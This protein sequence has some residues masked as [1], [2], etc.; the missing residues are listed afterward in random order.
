MYLIFI[1]FSINLLLLTSYVTSLIVYLVQTWSNFEQDVID[2]ATDQS[3]NRLRLCV[4]AGGRHFK[5]ML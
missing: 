5:H 1:Y 3:R 2:A 4:H